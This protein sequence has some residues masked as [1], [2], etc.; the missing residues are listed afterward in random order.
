[1][2]SKMFGGR[3]A[4]S[5]HDVPGNEAGAAAADEPQVDLESLVITPAGRQRF[6]NEHVFIHVHNEKTGGTTLTHGI[7]NV[8]GWAQTH[9]LRQRNVVPI[10]ALSA[11][12]R[13]QI[14]LFNAHRKYGEHHRFRE[15]PLYVSSM[16][17]PVTRF[18]SFYKFVQARP[19]HPSHVY[20][21]ERSL[22]DAYETLRSKARG[23]ARGNQQA[24]AMLGGD[25]EAEI[26]SEEVIEHVR[27][28]YFLVAP[29]NK[30]NAA[31][32][33]L[34]S[35]MKLPPVT[36][37]RLNVS[38]SPDLDVSPALRERLLE[39]NQVDTALIEF[40]K[41]DFD[42]RLTRAI[43]YIAEGCAARSDALNL[44]HRL[45]TQV[46]DLASFESSNA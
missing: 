4:K 14:R 35:A 18:V 30:I 2:W 44:S 12:D 3:A 46:R 41:A 9:D 8:V 17:E 36:P 34:R 29:M 10:E 37:Q 13:D 32:A 5:P 42:A 1:M 28:N 19:G 43:A 16:R 22:E 23:W 31:I 40:A 26:T 6:L 7:A 11:A 38:K 39:D 45:K 15:T 25:L 27:E 21:G 33:G 24:R 20:V